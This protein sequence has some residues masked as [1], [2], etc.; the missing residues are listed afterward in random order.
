MF[1]EASGF[2][3][4]VFVVVVLLLLM[5]LLCCRCSFHVLI[6]TSR[7]LSLL[8]ILTEI[9]CHSLLMTTARI[10]TNITVII[11]CKN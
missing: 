4:I 9:A 2:I 8:C 6:V 7:F 1:A 5:L 3:F 10:S 11:I